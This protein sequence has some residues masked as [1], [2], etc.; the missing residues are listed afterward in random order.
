MFVTTPEQGYILSILQETKFMRKDQV[1]KLL[2]SVDSRITAGY[3]DRCL[4]QMRHIR[5]ITW[6]T[7]DVICLPDLYKEPKDDEMLAAIDI[8]L[9]LTDFKILV[10]SAG[11]A[12]YKLCFLTE[13]SASLGSYAVIIVAPGS[14]EMITASL[15]GADPESRTII[16]LLPEILQKNNIETALPH[17]FA[18]YDGGKYRY[19]KGGGRGA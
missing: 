16:F 5:K 7:D 10:V 18:V 9:D 8:M 3:T 6:R 19:F 17:F 14:E 1:F 2:N 4:G 13:Q 12:P 15:H 11:P